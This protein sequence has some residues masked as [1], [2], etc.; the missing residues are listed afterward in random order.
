MA[1]AA[2]KRQHHSSV[3][4]PAGAGGDAQRVAQRAG[5][6]RGGTPSLSGRCSGPRRGPAQARPMMCSASMWRRVC[7]IKARSRRGT[8]SYAVCRRTPS[9]SLVA[10]KL[11]GP[12]ARARRPA[13]PRARAP[14]V[15]RACGAV[16]VLACCPDAR[17]LATCRAQAGH[18]GRRHRQPCCWPGA[19]GRLLHACASLQGDAGRGSGGR[20]A[21]HL[22]PAP[23][24]GACHW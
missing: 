11:R 7:W 5:P 23:A 17:R 18:G 20:R 24:M 15:L 13:R 1:H 9:R 19:A 8:S 2:P 4:R 21:A 14:W 16:A 22:V 10:S 6:C 3:R 12:A